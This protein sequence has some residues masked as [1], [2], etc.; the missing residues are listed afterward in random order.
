MF[1]RLVLRAREDAPSATP[2]L[3]LVD[4]L[5]HD[6]SNLVGDCLC[7][8]LYLDPPNTVSSDKSSHKK[9]GRLVGR[10]SSLIP[11]PAS[12]RGGESRAIQDIQLPSQS[13]RC[14]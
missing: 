4:A 14:T 6:V 12:K 5:V 7:V 9:P 13:K 1:F 8:V 3:S 2:F 11:F 10:N